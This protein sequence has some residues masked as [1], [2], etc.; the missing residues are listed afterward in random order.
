MSQYEAHRPNLDHIYWIGGS[1]CAGKSS[2]TDILAQLHKLHVYRCDDAFYEHEKII[3]QSKQPIFYKLTHLTSDELWLRP[4]DRQ[5]T[6][7]IAMYREEFPLILEDLLILPTTQPIIVEGNA[8]LPEQVCQFISD[9]RRAIWIVPTAEFQHHH[10]TRR[11]W[12]HNIVA[13]CS[14]PEQAFQNWMQRDI[15][16][17]GVIT[18]HATKQGMRVLLVDGKHSL[19]ENIASVKQHF[20]L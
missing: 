1:A 10:Y 4:V 3:T 6:E 13:T 14:D 8:L 5:I 12:A 20:Q 16:F 9:P 19:A 7:E 15:G 2:I 17:A 18:N 11:D